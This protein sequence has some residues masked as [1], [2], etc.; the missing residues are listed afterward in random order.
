MP[1][2]RAPPLRAATGCRRD[3][4]QARSERD[5]PLA[6][7]EQEQARAIRRQRTPSAARQASSKPPAA[8]PKKPAGRITPQAAA[9]KK[10]KVKRVAKVKPNT[11]QENII[12]L[13]S[14]DG[15]IDSVP[16]PRA[17]FALPLL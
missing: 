1:D 4:R 13:P 2:H 12:A 17:V 10:A 14:A 16:S 7:N 5:I 3:M 9:R 11:A 15:A 8:K 6:G